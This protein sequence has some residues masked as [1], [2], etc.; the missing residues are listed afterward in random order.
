MRG[1]CREFQNPDASALS[2]GTVS[3]SPISPPGHDG[4]GRVS[5]KAAPSVLPV[6]P[7]RCGPGM[8]TLGA[9][10]YK[11]KKEAGKESRPGT[12]S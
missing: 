9:R 11:L 10:L 3:C 12:V 4:R 5:G 7:S 8:G 1:L 2:W 6:N